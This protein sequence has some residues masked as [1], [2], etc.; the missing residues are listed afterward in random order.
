[1][2]K[3][4][5]RVATAW[6]LFACTC[7]CLDTGGAGTGVGLYGTAQGE[8][9]LREAAIQAMAKATRFATTEVATRGG[10]LWRYK[11]DMSMREG[12][13]A[14]TPSMI[15]VQPPGTP[16]VGMAF[17]EAYE[18]TADSVYLEAARDAAR[19]LVWGQ[20]VSGGWDY[21]I[22]FDPKK[23]ERWYYRRDAEAGDTNQAE[24]RNR[25]T[26]DDNTTQSALRL[27]M[28][29]DK[30][31]DI[32]D[33]EIHR[34]AMYA[35]GALLKAQYPNGAWP[36]RYETF[37]D[38]EQFPVKRARYPKSWSRTYPEERYYMLYTF[39]DGAILDVIETMIEAYHTYGDKRYLEAARR[40]G[41]FLILSQMPEPQPAWAQQYNVDMEPAWA[42]WFE[43]PAITGGESFGVMGTLMDLYLETGEQ[44]YLEPIPRALAWAERSI[45]PDG[46]LARFY[47]LET[48]KA[49]YFTP[50]QRMTYD[51]SNLRPGYAFKVPVSRL[52]STEAY[53]RKI[54]T[55][56]REAILRQRSERLVRPTH[57]GRNSKVAPQ[58]VRA[59]IE[60]LDARGRWVEHGTLRDPE[61]REKRIE[62][63]VISC[64]TFNGNLTLLARYIKGSN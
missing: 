42:R 39:N 20:L 29:T 19:A 2:M 7:V 34:A 8:D 52:K 16:A 9:G 6:L 40:G 10:Y 31:L 14:A 13:R 28:R 54:R 3:N 11:S 5:K 51:D 45:L 17:L 25:T 12:E 56:G 47:E 36:Q 50:D 32:E 27:L 18:A 60:A 4:V 44:R 49:L 24:R 48:N 15:W 43:P 55:Q 53:Y 63:R 35:L 1:M 59:V 57:G 26:L 41:Q 22:D 21:A 58:Q 30:V 61:N 64:R 37:P 23:S 33:E 62:T 46:R 38:P